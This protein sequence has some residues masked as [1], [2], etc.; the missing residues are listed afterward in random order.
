MV[1]CE[2]QTAAKLLASEPPP[3]SQI[4]RLASVQA[5]AQSSCTECSD[6]HEVGAESCLVRALVRFCSAS[7]MKLTKSFLPQRSA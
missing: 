6:A 2:W 7:T 3:Q 1:H 5:S 4:V